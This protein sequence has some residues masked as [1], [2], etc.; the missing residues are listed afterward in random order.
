MPLA[1]PRRSVSAFAAARLAK[2]PKSFPG[3]EQEPAALPKPDFEAADIAIVPYDDR[4]DDEITGYGPAAFDEVSKISSTHF[5]SFDKSNVSQNDN[6]GAQVILKPGQSI[7]A[8]GVYD[9][10]VLKGSVVLYGAVLRP[11]GTVPGSNRPVPG[12]GKHRVFA[13]SNSALP[14]ILARRDGASI[15]LSTVRSAFD[16]LGKLSPLFRNISSGDLNRSFTILRTNQ[17]DALQR[18]LGALESDKEA[19]SLIA[20]LSNRS[21]MRERQCT[22]VVGAK[23]AGKSTFNRMLCNSITTMNPESRCMY[24]DIDPG[25]PE[26]GPP[27]QI[28]LVE[29]VKPLLGPPYSH[30]AT[31]SS[32]YFRSLRCHA[33]ASTSFK[34]NPDHYLGCVKDLIQYI[35]HRKLG[36]LPLVV[37]SCGWVNGIGANVLVDVVLSLHS[38]SVDLVVLEPVDAALVQTIQSSSNSI[39][40][41]R[42]PRRF[43]RSSIRTPAELRNMQT[44]A[45]FHH[46]EPTT[47]SSQSTWL[48]EPIDSMWPYSVAYDG[49]DPDILAVLSYSYSPDPE[50]LA[51]VLDGSIVAV[52]KVN[53]QAFD[54]EH[55]LRQTDA[56]VHERAI[57]HNILRTPE[58]LP[59]LPSEYSMPLEPKY[60]E[61]I[62][63][64]LVRSI[65][66][67]HKRLL[68]ITPT[69]RD[70]MTTN[71]DEHIVLVRGAF[72]PPEWAYLESLH[73]HDEPGNEVDV[74]DRPWVSRREMVGVEGAVWRMRHPPLASSVAK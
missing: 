51:E 67:D 26:F 70:Q 7:T 64:A 16:K 23:S 34:D 17:D 35:S 33:I 30:P 40:V 6:L 5:S 54:S 47:N 20:T 62:G 72:D 49:I 18:S 15:K 2:Q 28:S 53:D 71:E 3:I 38:R 50:L 32:P 25:Q 66:Y 60:S 11:R 63:L 46:R 24:L 56:S 14:Q 42:L 73:F 45:Y 9:V 74:E 12:S 48:G 39:Y 58:G 21:E 68:L 65:D 37:N 59:Y 4:L 36:S 52:V 69:P 41:H 1:I 57:R 31:A 29:V 19:S 22:L 10:Q 55:L 44:M 13:L 27:G 43:T 8:I 61:C